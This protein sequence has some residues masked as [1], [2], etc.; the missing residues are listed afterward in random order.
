MKPSVRLDFALYAGD[1]DSG[2]PAIPSEVAVTEVR[3]GKDR[4]DMKGSPQGAI[5]IEKDGKSLAKAIPDPIIPLVAKL[6]RT[7]KYLIEGEPES[8]LFSESDHG[9]ALERIS[10]EVS[11]SYF[12]GS[13]SYEPESHLVKELLIPLDDFAAQVIEMGEK[14]VQMAPERMQ[15]GEE[16]LVEFLELAKGELKSRRLERERTRRR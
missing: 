11:L 4:F 10:D 1:P 7:I 14:L 13:D 3:S 6:L 8:V 15:E 9:F 16:G 2:A 12:V 5:T